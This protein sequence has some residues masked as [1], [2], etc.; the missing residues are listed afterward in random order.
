M[1]F[2]CWFVRTD[3]SPVDEAVFTIEPLKKNPTRV[4]FL[5]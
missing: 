1:V 2:I 5:H 3:R 4:A